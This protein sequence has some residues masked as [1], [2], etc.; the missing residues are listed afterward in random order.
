MY[1][2]VIFHIGGVILAD[3][4]KAKGIVSGM[5]NGNK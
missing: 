5:I 2:F 1:A 3:L 4:G